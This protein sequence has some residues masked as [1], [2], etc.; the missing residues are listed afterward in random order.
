MEE[1]A[2]TSFKFNLGSE[3]KDQITGF[4]G[5]VT[6]R[7]QWINNCN[8]YGVQCQKLK[9]GIPTESQRFDEPQLELVK[10][11]VF[12]SNQ[13]SGGPDRKVQQPNR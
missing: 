2:A 8:T 6:S 7:H 12:E 11:E 3:V 9:D 5:I 13:R 4:T 1:I 10:K